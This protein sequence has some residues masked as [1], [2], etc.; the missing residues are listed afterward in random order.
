MKKYL[1][2]SRDY[3]KHEEYKDGDYKALLCRHKIVSDAH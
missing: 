3:S 1:T 2:G